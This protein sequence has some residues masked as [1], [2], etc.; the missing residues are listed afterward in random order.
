MQ[1]TLRLLPPLP[2]PIPLA[3]PFPRLLRTMPIADTPIPL[4]Q[5]FIPRHVV[6]V[7]VPLYEGKVPCEERVEFEETCAIYFERLEGGS[8]GTLGGATACYDGFDSEG[9]VGSFSWFYLGKYCLV[10]LEINGDRWG[11]NEP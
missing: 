6:R 1:P 2:P 7:D 11:K 10:N 3:L 4:T 5:Q 9:V 8:V